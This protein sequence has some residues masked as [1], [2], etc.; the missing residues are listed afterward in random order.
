MFKK[1][2]LAAIF[3][4]FA[5]VSSAQTCPTRPVGDSSN[6]CA[7]TAFVQ[8]TLNNLTSLTVANI[9]GG[10]LPTSTLTLHDTSNAS[11]T[12]AAILFRSR[13]GATVTPTTN[14]GSDVP[15]GYNPWQFLATNMTISTAGKWF[16]L[17]GT[18]STTYSTLF[19]CFF[20]VTQLGQPPST[21][22]SFVDCG[23]YTNPDIT[24]TGATNA[25]PIVIT[26]TNH[27]LTNG[28][29]VQ[30]NG[31]LGNTAANTTW[32]VGSVTTNTFAL[33]G[34]TGNG[35]YT[36]GGTA[37]I[38][39]YSNMRTA[40]VYVNGQ[41][42]DVNALGG[43]MVSNRALSGGSGIFGFG[44]CAD[45]GGASI[46]SGAELSVG[47][48]TTGIPCGN[49]IAAR[50]ECGGSGIAG[51]TC[52]AYTQFFSGSANNSPLFGISL[53]G[54][55]QNSFQPTGTVIGNADAA[56]HVAYGLDWHN[57]T[58]D[59]CSYRGVATFCI[60]GS[61][62]LIGI[63]SGTAGSPSARWGVDT[64]AG[65]LQD[66]GAGT[67][68]W[69]SG[70]VTR[71]VL[72]PSQIIFTPV[73]ALGT[74]G[75]SI[76]DGGAGKALI[77]YQNTASNPTLLLPTSS[78]TFASGASSPLVLSATTGN[79]TC[80]TCLANTP[81][82]LTK[83]DDT[84][85]TLTLGGT[86]ATALL[87]ATSLTLGWTGVLSGTRGGTGV[88]NGAST[89]TVGGN[90]STTGAFA[91]GTA[92]PTSG[93]LLIGSGSAFV[94]Q[95]MSGDVTIS[96]TGVTAIGANKVTNAQRAQMA[97]NT[98][99]GNNTGS[100]ANEADL[101]IAQLAAQFV[102]P[103]TQSYCS[104]GCTSSTASGTF[105]TPAGA[106]WLKLTLVGGGGSGSGS[107]TAPGAGTAG[108]PTCWN[109]SGAA[110]STPVFQAGGGGAGSAL[111][112]TAAGGTI[113]GSS[114]P[115]VLSIPGGT[116]AAGGQFANAFGGFGGAS[117]CGIGTPQI[118]AGP[119]GN[120]GINA[121]GYGNGGGGASST[122]T[123]VIGGGG[124]GGGCLTTIITA[125]VASYTYV[126]G[127]LVTGGAAG[128]TGAT[129]GSSSAGGVFIEVHYN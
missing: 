99:K 59:T 93:N 113:S 51:S 10:N 100:P 21:D 25:T 61:D 122:L 92:T 112:A 76:Q 115:N 123:S 57:A 60:D 63:P 44:A 30:I 95:A 17:T 3:C 84:N 5:S 24:I 98:V 94:T 27:G 4:L 48:Y 2:S 35:A 108:N 42:M 16:G 65:L 12:S 110:C 54:N 56:F 18:P 82:A 28:Q 69:S 13:G 121:N 6:A 91:V 119:G 89:I 7:S 55:G 66:S 81:A 53:S 72:S 22:T 50:F 34:S 14:Q 86:P 101:T 70:G 8:N 40:I 125:P 109:T 105:T 11:A 104:S 39:Q 102:V 103:T 97:A 114:T 118:G 37:T 129:G 68:S 9:Y 127:A 45:P 126:Y 33:V 85:V 74:S 77:Q 23:T 26:A 117:S 41:A 79:L 90:L 67:L 49:S 38:V 106:T 124:G 52:F 15:D 36:S 29:I 47:C 107:G 32:T 75:L 58:I 46:C 31:V 64:N 87:Q 1:L 43:T 20:P 83:T 96:S 80:P 73:L 111:G 19:N 116:G 120:N 78:G 88:N 128:T 71:V 62:K